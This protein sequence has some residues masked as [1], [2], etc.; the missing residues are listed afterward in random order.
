MRIGGL[1]FLVLVPL[2]NGW[3]QGVKKDSVTQAPQDSAVLRHDSTKRIGNRK[4]ITIETYAKRFDPRKALFYSAVLPGAGQAYNKKYWKIPLVF[5]G[6]WGL[7]SV[8]KFYDDAEE[9]YTKQ[10]YQLINYPN[11]PLY[12]GIITN[13]AVEPE[14][15]N[16]V[17]YAR[18][19]RDYFVIITGFFYI[20][21]MVDAHVDAHLKEFDVNPKLHVR[22]EPRWSPMQGI[23]MG[24]TARF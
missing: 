4:V 23:G 5:G 3:A 22:L 6:F 7:L 11:I 19:Q 21:Q 10:L 1:F 8:V 14:L 2:V 16:R 17:D 9:K 24:L 15:R 12:P 20:L 18:R 13:A